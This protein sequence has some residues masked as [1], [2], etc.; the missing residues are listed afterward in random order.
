[1]AT[2]TRQVEG[3]IYHT[4]FDDLDSW[5]LPLHPEYCA[6]PMCIW[7]DLNRPEPWG[8]LSYGDRASDVYY[9][10]PYALKF[11]VQSTYYAT[12][13]LPS[14]R[15][16]HLLR[17]ITI[18]AGLTSVRMQVRHRWY[19]HISS[20]MTIA[21]KITLGT[22]TFL[23]QQPT[24]AEDT[25]AFVNSTVSTSPGSQSLVVGIE[26]Y[27]T[28]LYHYANYNNYWFDELVIA[29]GTT[30]AVSG[31]SAGYKAKLYDSSDTLIAEATESGGTASIDVSSKA[32]PITA[33]IKITDGSDVVQYTSALYDDLFGG[34]QFLYATSGS[35]LTAST[36]HYIIYRTGAS[37]SP[38]SATITFTLKDSEGTPRAGKTVEFSTTHGSLSA[39]S[40]VTDGN[41]EVSVTLTATAKGLAVVKATY[42]ETGVPRAYQTIEV[43][44]HHDVDSPDPDGDYEVWAQ[45]LRLYD[46]LVV[47]IQESGTTCVATVE[48]SDIEHT[49]ESG[50][51]YAIYH[52]GALIFTGRIEVITKRIDPEEVT[53]FEG[54]N[55]LQTLMWIPISAA[56]YSAQ[57]L[58]TMIE[59]IILTYVD[60]LK[61]VSQG[62]ISPHLDNI[63][64]TVEETDTTAFDLLQRIAG[65]G[66]ASLFVNKDR[67]VNIV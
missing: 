15:F 61:Q 29:R 30:I 16:I 21:R 46:L 44:V 18:P 43:S 37:G 5:T 10:S 45:G 49:V 66:G 31:L 65:L 39:S 51:D 2:L 63:T 33:R 12:T 48:T 35:V 47:N 58:K 52:K 55:F 19:H 3:K 57:S 62:E 56:S 38:T 64:A 40:G 42:E 13:N 14:G 32:Y 27:N 36:N 54:R 60:P 20:P 7:D 17:D 23:N 6:E 41:G 22:Q 24:D 26:S 4:K 11:H 1:M 9:S 59:S 50:Y 67:E 34:D 53:K 8:T 25:W 28:V